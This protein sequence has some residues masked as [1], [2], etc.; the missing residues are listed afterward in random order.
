MTF[1]LKW[2]LPYLIP[3]A[4]D[5]VIEAAKGKVKDTRSNID[6]KIVS[7][8]ESEK[9]TLAKDAVN[10]VKQGVRRWKR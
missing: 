9:E 8:I 7:V 4:I 5:F 2:I 3:S 1:L 6:D 10:L